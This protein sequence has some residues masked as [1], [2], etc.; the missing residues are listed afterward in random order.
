MPVRAV[1]AGA[2][3]AWSACTIYDN[4]YA[5]TATET[6]AN[7]RE[8]FFQSQ[9]FQERIG[10]HACHAGNYD[11]TLVPQRHSPNNL[12]SPKRSRMEH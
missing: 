1:A 12:T 7:T 9:R 11:A 4:G 3:I 2:C 10:D 5:S 8:R 6:T